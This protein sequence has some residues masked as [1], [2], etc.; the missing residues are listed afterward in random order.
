MSCFKILPTLFFL[1]LTSSVVSADVINID[2]QGGG[3]PIDYT[4][5]AAA[6]DPNAVPFWNIV[7][8]AGGALTRSDGTASG[9]TLNAITGAIAFQGFLQALTMSTFMAACSF[10]SLP[11]AS[12]DPETT[13]SPSMV[14]ARV[15]T[16]P[17]SLTEAH[18]RRLLQVRTSSSFQ[19]SPSERG[20]V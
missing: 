18:R 20:P 15:L 7:G 1:A 13:P 16:I 9:A 11:M 10:K 2:I 12:V 17:G 4:G 3:T 19:V 8:L 6:P 5:T 14:P